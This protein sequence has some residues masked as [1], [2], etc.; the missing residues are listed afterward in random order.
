MRKTTIALTTSLLFYFFS[1]ATVFAQAPE[2]EFSFGYNL[3]TASFDH[4]T[5]V[6]TDDEGLTSGSSSQLGI[7][8]SA[9]IIKS[10]LYLRSH[11]GFTSATGLYNLEYD[12]DI[13]QGPRNRKIWTWY[14]TK[15]VYLSL[16]PEF[17]YNFDFSEDAGFPL[18]IHVKANGGLLLHSDISNLSDAVDLPQF[19]VLTPSVNGDLIEGYTFGFGGAITLNNIG[20]SLNFTFLRF[21]K[22]E[23][24]SEADPSIIYQQR[25]VSVGIFY[26]L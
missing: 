13:G 2:L 25:V 15:R 11:F 20:A 23:L 18:I 16:T 7:A 4:P 3:T 21:G 6:I 5:E 14:T 19:D 12:F 1:I 26:R 22:S 8:V 17:R 10:S 9:P 24:F